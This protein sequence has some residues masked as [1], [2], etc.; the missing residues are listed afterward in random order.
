[1]M[2]LKPLCLPTNGISPK[3]RVNT[4][5]KQLDHF[6]SACLSLSHAHPITEPEKRAEGQKKWQRGRKTT[7]L[8]D[9]HPICAHCGHFVSSQAKGFISALKMMLVRPFCRSTNE[10]WSYPR[11]RNSTPS[12]I[13][14]KCSNLRSHWLKVKGVSLMRGLCEILRR[15]SVTR[16]NGLSLL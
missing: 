2:I 12:P 8:T 14:R 9:D 13:H 5:E 10:F 3:H 7:L 16:Q 15:L 6:T 1:M 11:P 4:T